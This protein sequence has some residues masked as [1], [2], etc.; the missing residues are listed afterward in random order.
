MPPII[1]KEKCIKCGKCADVCS[2]DVFYGTEKT[3][4]PS[5][6]YP[7]EC[8][9]CSACQQECPVDGAIRIRVPLSMMI[10]YK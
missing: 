7:E 10:V 6:T 8:W 4:F 1:N 5:V 9:H 2:E 3:G